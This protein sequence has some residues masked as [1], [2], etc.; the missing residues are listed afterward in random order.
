MSAINGEVSVRILSSR[1]L[2][3]YSTVPISFEGSSAAVVSADLSS[4]HEVPVEP[5]AKDY[6]ALE[7]PT[8]W[9]LRFDMSRWLVAVA[10]SG[11]QFVGG[12]IV[13]WDTSGV[14]M[15][16]GRSDLAVLWDI[17][18]DPDWRGKGVGRLLFDFASSWAILRGCT[19]LKIET[20]DINLGA[21]RFYRSMGCHVSEV[22]PDAYDDCPGEAQIIWRK[23]LR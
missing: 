18:V 22:V 4:F 13:A 9:A 10:C 6:D 14:D 19:E 20:Q 1:D 7:N 2:A 23:S 3:E 8:N 12:C 11:D 21:C 17:R 16:E 15:L 5:F